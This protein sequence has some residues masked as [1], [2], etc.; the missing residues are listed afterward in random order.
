MTPR[1]RP[2]VLTHRQILTDPVE[3]AEPLIAGLLNRAE[4]MLF[5]GP[6]GV[7]KTWLLLSLARAVASG[8]TWLCHFATAQ[9]P[10]LMVDEESHVPGIRARA[11]LLEAGEE[12]GDD[13]PIGYA[14]GH[15]IRL[16]RADD[17]AYLDGLM[18]AHKPALV[19]LDSLTR[20]HGADENS[21]GQMADV[22]RNVRMLM[23]THGASV[24]IADHLRKRGLINDPEE[25]L[26][27][28]TEKRAFPECILFAAPAQDGQVQITHVKARYTRRLDDFT[29]KIAVDEEAA[30]VRHT[31]AAVPSRVAKLNE[32]VG[33]VHAVKA[34]LGNDASDARTVALY[35]ECSEDT[36]NRHL[37]KLVAAELVVARRVESGER[38]RPRTVYDVKGATDGA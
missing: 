8:S 9:G 11:R 17:W 24:V 18:A 3:D 1:D 38:G 6:P 26:R 4:A 29:V 7:G 33:A 30:T 36:A 23:R 31:G 13:L 10:V 5:A 15:G 34:Q 12:L 32:V 2:P 16:D 35:L 22:F 27:G 20:I 25:M 14:I 21:A 28:S 37:K 19:T